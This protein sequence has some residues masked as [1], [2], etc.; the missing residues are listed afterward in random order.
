M[1]KLSV[2][3]LMSLMISGCGLETVSIPVPPADANYLLFPY[4]KLGPDLCPLMRVV[5]PTYGTRYIGWKTARVR[6]VPGTLTWTRQEQEDILLVLNAL[7]GAIGERVFKLVPSGSEAE[8]TLTGIPFN[9][10]GPEVIG[11]TYLYLG[12]SGKLL[13]HVG[14]KR[15]YNKL[16][17]P[18]LMHEMG[19]A[20]GL[21]HSSLPGSVMYP[22]TSEL[23]LP[24]YS[25][26]EIKSLRM[27][28]GTHP[29]YYLQ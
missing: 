26:S 7:N 2:A 25:P 17:L 29:A 20:A 6:Y 3:F 1:S 16:F 11:V 9:L 8:I 10:E 27:I 15:E 24:K 23:T 28:S 4:K 14:M 5:Y 19:H 12:D 18:A 21:E 22:Y 13:A